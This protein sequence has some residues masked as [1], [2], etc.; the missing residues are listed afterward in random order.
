[1]GQ[2]QQ[3]QRQWRSFLRLILFS[4]MGGSLGVLGVLFTLAL[5]LVKV[6]IHPRKWTRFDLHTF[7]PFELGL[8]GE[9][10]AFPPREGNYLVSGWYIPYPEATTTILLCPGYRCKAEYV[11]NLALPLWKAGHTLLVFEYYGHGA[12]VMTPVTLGYRE[13]NDFLGAVAYIRARA[14]AA[15]LGVLAYSM[16]ASV[17]LMAGAQTNDV[18]AFVVD[19]AFATHRRV[20]A[21]NFRRSVHL[22]FGLV[23][24]MTDQLL[25]R[26]AGYHL[27]QVEPLRDIG[28]LAP[29]PV[30]LIQG[31]KDSVVDPQDALLLYQAANAPKELWIVP[32][33]E[34]CGA[35]FVDRLA[36]IARVITF[37]D[38]HLKKKLPSS[39][40]KN[41]FQEREG[42]NDL[43][44]GLAEEGWTWTSS[45]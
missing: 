38:L 39:P 41:A 2:Q 6:L 35:Y 14:P 26:L 29:R 21:Y 28:R 10:V 4:S 13:I 34:H 12:P 45:A 8:P 7:T 24:L 3:Q 44:D 9:A 11:L 15:G 19:S 36:Y 40:T 32:E 33:A 1:M 17:A 5:S 23:A 16:G 30:L 18:E 22:P 42:P 27:D 25:W 37:F 31:E 43:R 20:L